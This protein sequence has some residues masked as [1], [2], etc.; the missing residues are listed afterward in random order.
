MKRIRYCQGCDR[1]TLKENC[2]I[3]GKETII[4]TPQKYSKDEEVAKYRRQIKRALLQKD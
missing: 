3:C 2:A 4:N 1:Y